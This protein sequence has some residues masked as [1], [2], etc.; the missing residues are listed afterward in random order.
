MLEGNTNT[1][2]WDWKDSIGPLEERPGFSGVWN[3]QQSHGLGC[4]F[5]L[6]RH[7]SIGMSIHPYSKTTP[8]DITSPYPH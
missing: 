1:S 6:L 7:F 3:Y 2:Y 5:F 8:D 4:K